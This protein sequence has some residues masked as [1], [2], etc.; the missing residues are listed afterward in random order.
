MLDNVQYMEQKLKRSDGGVQYSESL[1]L[2]TLSISGI[3]NNSKTRRFGNWIFMW[4]QEDT[5]SVESFGTTV[6]KSHWLPP[7]TW[8]WKQVKFPKSS[9]FL[10]IVIP[11][12]GQSPETQRFWLQCEACKKR[13]EVVYVCTIKKIKE[14]NSVAWV[15][16]RTMPTA[17]VV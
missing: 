9:V 11:N 8:G 5:C 17:T 16:E 7:L 15:G 3:L 2:W 10:L 13:R 4:G 14:L 1:A 6:S 12:D